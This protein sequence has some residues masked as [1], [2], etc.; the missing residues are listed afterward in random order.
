VVELVDVELDPLEPQPASS[1][2]IVS[3]AAVEPVRS[4]VVSMRITP[5]C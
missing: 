5:E 1:M 2:R 4:K 3:T